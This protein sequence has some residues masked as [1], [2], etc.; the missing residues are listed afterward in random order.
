LQE[1]LDSLSQADGEHEIRLR[2]ALVRLRGVT[3]LTD[4]TAIQAAVLAASRSIEESLDQIHKQHELTVSQF[5]VE[6]R[7]LHKR[8]DSLER[9]ASMDSLTKLLSRAEIESRLR[10]L[11]DT[12]LAVLLIRVEGFI[13]ADTEYGVDVGAELAAAFTKRMRN[14]LPANAV[15]ARWG[16]E[17]FV[18]MIAG[19]STGDA[20]A[21]AK[22]ISDHLSGAYACLLNGKTVR[23][24]VSLAVDIV[25]GQGCDADRILHRAGKFFNR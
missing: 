12:R 22:W 11:P 2:A 8:I 16:D 14:S 10:S 13:E 1:I 24:K 9:A 3:G 4:P 21:N 5:L 19:L 6:I 7:M 18:A 15:I 25:E 23:P 20:I 17:D